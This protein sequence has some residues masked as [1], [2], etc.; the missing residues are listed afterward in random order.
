[1]HKSQSNSV[2][3][4]R[5]V[6]KTFGSMAAVKDIKLE[7]M[8]GEIFGFLGP[9]GAGKTTTIKLILDILRPTTGTIDLFG[10]SNRQTSTTHSR[11]GYL[12]GEMVLD[13]DLTG[14][15]YLAFVGHTY[16]GD[17]SER[18]EALAAKLQ[19][20]LDVKI[21][22]YSRGNKQKIGLIAAL[23]HQPDLL[24]LDEPSSG[25]DPLMQE[26]FIKLIEDYRRV[27]GTVF[28]SSHTLA[29]VQRLCDR[30]AFIRDGRLVGVTT[31]DELN[32][33]AS[34]QIRAR[35]NHDLI[36]SIKHKAAN[37]T[38]LKLIESHPTRLTFTYSGDTQSLLRFFADYELDDLTIQEPEL[39]EVFMSYYQE[40]SEAE[41][42]VAS[43]EKP[44]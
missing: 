40:K 10:I 18:M 11:I 6:T 44:K 33:T 3:A 17:Y 38:N 1:M 5:G 34:K 9:N 31:I 36:A 37:V 8:T 32:Q 26:L 24:I 2:L 41:V 35:A 23:M 14:R 13:D 16:G 28:M 42:G 7:I 30:V 15:Q 21:G 25:F 22:N 4:I 29:E 19:A 12:S 27:G 20:D 43:G 39:E